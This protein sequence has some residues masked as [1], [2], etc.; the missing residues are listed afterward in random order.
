MPIY[1]GNTE[2]DGLRVGA[3]GAARAYVGADEAW[4]ALEDASVTATI[5]PVAIGQSATTERLSATV[6]GNWDTITYAWTVNKGTLDNAAAASPVWT[7]PTVMADEIARIR[8]T[9]SVT[10]TG[11]NAVDGSTARDVAR[12]VD[13]SVRGVPEVYG[14]YVRNDDTVEA[15]GPWQA[16]NNYRGAGADREREWTR[17][18]TRS[19]TETS[20]SN[21]GNTRTRAWSVNISATEWRAAPINLPGKPGSPT[22]NLRTLSSDR[23]LRAWQLVVFSSRLAVAGDNP[24]LDYQLEWWLQSTATGGLIRDRNSQANVAY[25][26]GNL[27]INFFTT[28]IPDTFHEDLLATYPYLGGRVRARSVDGYGPWSDATIRGPFTA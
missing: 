24:I 11:R 5:N 2:I 7:R 28:S 4:T 19:G 25:T 16:T 22:V 23:D 6:T 1:V 15:Y 27:A 12:R 10:G 18:G 26:S 9:V 21:Y 20:T 3:G 17:S 8:L 14:E 13:T